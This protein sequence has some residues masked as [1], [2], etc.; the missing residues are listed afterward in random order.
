MGSAR[1]PS[2]EGMA[3]LR[4]T[5]ELRRH[6]WSERALK[7]GSARVLEVMSSSSVAQLPSGQLEK[8]VLEI[9]RTVQ[10]TKIAPAL[11]VVHERVGVARVAEH[12]FTGSLAALAA[13]SS[14]LPRPALGGVAVDLDHVRLDVA[15][16][17]LARG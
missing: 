7:S 6:T 9:R 5:R 4:H 16:D 15:L 1:F 13:R 2:I 17:Q 14:E 3:S 11:E 10:E 12:R 8:H